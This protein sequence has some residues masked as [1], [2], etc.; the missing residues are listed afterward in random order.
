[1]SCENNICLLTNNQTKIDA[2]VV[3]YVPGRRPA[4]AT[5]KTVVVVTSTPAPAPV[6]V[7]SSKVEVPKFETPAPA[8]VVP[9]SK[10][11]VPKFETPAP[12]PVVVQSSKVEV[13]KAETPAPAPVVEEP[14]PVVA[15]TPTPEKAETAPVTP[16][17]G[18]APAAAPAAGDYQGSVLYHHNVHRANHSTPDMT[19]SD[20]LASYA[21]TVAKT[22]TWGHDL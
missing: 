21:L 6:V 18:E 8:P 20:T 15:V 12:A 14:A 19:Y 17:V 9:S 16:V 11:E 4:K 3:G 2:N 7:P 13:P 22:C 10:V 1:M 5:T